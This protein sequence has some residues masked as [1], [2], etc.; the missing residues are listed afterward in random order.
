M[1]SLCLRHNVPREEI[2][3]SLMNID[4]DNISTLL[5]AVRKFLSKTLSDGTKLKL[6]CPECGE[7]LVIS[8]GCQKCQKCLWSACG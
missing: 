6:V 3:V 4:G 5:T 1:V 8:N 7:S 2:L